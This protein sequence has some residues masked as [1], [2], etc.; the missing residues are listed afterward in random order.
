MEG[1]GAC[2]RCGK[3]GH[4]AK[5]CTMQVSET[6]KVPARVFALT[7]AEADASPSV[8]SGNILVQAFLHT[9]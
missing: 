3:L 6:R 9:H 4:F 1:P 8:V 2:Y 5:D 7:Q